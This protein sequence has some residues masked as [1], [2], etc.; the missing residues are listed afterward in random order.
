MPDMGVGGYMLTP[1]PIPGGAVIGWGLGVMLFVFTWSFDPS[2]CC[3]CCAPPLKSIGPG[4]VKTLTAAGATG[5]GPAD[6]DMWPG[7]PSV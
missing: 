2:G 7:W 5:L 1:R 6:M 3:S 4:P